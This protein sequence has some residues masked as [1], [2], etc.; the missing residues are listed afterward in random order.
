MS[1]SRWTYYISDICDN[2]PATA[3]ICT[4]LWFW[5][6]WCHHDGY[7]HESMNIV[8]SHVVN[9]GIE[10]PRFIGTKL[11]GDSFNG[12]LAH[13]KGSEK[14]KDGSRWEPLK[15]PPN[16]LV[17]I[18]LGPSMAEFTTDFFE[19]ASTTPQPK[20]PLE[21][22]PR[23]LHVAPTSASYSANSPPITPIVVW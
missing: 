10:G 7:F 16:N 1:L 22:P 15:E 6:F 3:K 19:P 21:P 13:L 9:S 23:H 8:L 14:L 4:N 20:P 5:G 18:N 2:F 11:F 17:P 12:S